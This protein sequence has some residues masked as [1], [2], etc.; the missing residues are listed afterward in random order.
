[1]EIGCAESASLKDTV[2][3][4]KL[5]I[6]P[7][8]TLLLAQARREGVEAITGLPMFAHQ[9]LAQF[10]RWTGQRFPL[11]EAITLLEETLARRKA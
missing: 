3:T 10:E 6:N 9:G 4:D 11:P 8:E 2:S 5:R 1:M 7:K